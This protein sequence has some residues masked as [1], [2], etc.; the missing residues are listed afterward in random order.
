MALLGA[1]GAGKTTT[2]L[3]LSGEL[4]P[5][6]GE[7]LLNGEKVTTPRRTSGGGAGWPT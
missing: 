1:N 5:L 2:L 4:R 6:G 3:A 7:I